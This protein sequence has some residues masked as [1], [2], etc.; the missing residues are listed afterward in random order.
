MSV[1]RTRILLLDRNRHTLVTGSRLF[2]SPASHKNHFH[3]ARSPLPSLSTIMILYAV[4]ARVIDGVVLVDGS[5]PELKGNFQQVAT[6]FLSR[7]IDHRD[8]LTEGTRKTFIHQ[9]PVERDYLSYFIDS[10]ASAIGEVA[11]HEDSDLTASEYYFHLLVRKDLYFCCLG[12]DPDTRDQKVSFAFLDAMQAEFHKIYRNPTR[13]ANANAYAFQKAFT[14]NIR[15]Q[16]HYHNTNHTSIAQEDRVRDLLAQVSDMKG[17]MGR[18]ITLLLD[19]GDS[20][21]RLSDKS[22]MALSDA[23]VFRKQAQ[24]HRNRQMR[25]YYVSVFFTLLAISF[26]IFILSVSICGVG[27]KHCRAS[28]TSNN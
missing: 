11:P 19:R 13:I 10:C 20:L 14:P 17:V 25:R 21:Q 23:S 5:S 6:D 28:N 22:Q 2:R 15:A 12:D 9:N 3:S 26:F 4:I 27:L 7:L 8:E 18:N 16:M 1:G 24:Y